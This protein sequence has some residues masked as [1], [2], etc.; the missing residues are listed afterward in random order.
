MAYENIHVRPA[1]AYIIG[2]FREEC[3]RITRGQDLHDL[4]DEIINELIAFGKEKNLKLHRFKRTMGLPRV[5]KVLGYLKAFY[6]QKLLDIG[7][8]RGVFLC[9]LWDQINFLGREPKLVTSVHGK[10]THR[11]FFTRTADILL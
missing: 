3:Q 5:S 10:E 8:G 4:T 9:L 7:T 1:T 6:P 2:M 11:I